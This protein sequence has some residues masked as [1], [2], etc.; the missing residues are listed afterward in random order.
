MSLKIRK[1][2]QLKQMRLRQVS[3]R[4]ACSVVLAC[5]RSA[6]KASTF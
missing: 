6:H 4:G 3:V 5:R 1:Q 2:M